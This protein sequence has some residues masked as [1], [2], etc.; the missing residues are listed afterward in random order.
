[1]SQWIEFS[2]FVIG[3]IKRMYAGS[4]PNSLAC[5]SFGCSS[6]SRER[7]FVVRV[8]PFRIEGVVMAGGSPTKLWS[9]IIPKK[10]K[11]SNRLSYLY[12]SIIRSTSRF[13]RSCTTFGLASHDT[14]IASPSEPDTGF[15][16]AWNC[17]WTIVGGM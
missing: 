13:T 15:S 3:Q 1:M 17:E 10:I 9:P 5:S 6:Q 4:K 14:V 12:C 11:S 8:Y 16:R 7:L 2:T